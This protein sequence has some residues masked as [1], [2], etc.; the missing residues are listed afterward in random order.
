MYLPCWSSFLQ[1]VELHRKN[2]L[3]IGRPL[4]RHSNSIG[5]RDVHDARRWLARNKI[6]LVVGIFENANKA[7]AHWKRRAHYSA[8]CCSATA[9]ETLFHI[10][11]YY[12]PKSSETPVNK[13]FLWNEGR[14]FAWST[15]T[16]LDIKIKWY[17]VDQGIGQY[18][19]WQI[20]WKKRA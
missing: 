6:Q 5:A 7:S 8:A 14:K 18:I 2:Q 15:R 19:F 17:R 13:G 20:P 11:L 12:K 4:A 9:C 3:P 10:W 1:K 16:K